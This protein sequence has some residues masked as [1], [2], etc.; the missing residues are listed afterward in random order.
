MSERSHDRRD[1]LAAYLLGALE[2]GEMAELDRHLAG[3]E[4]CREQLTWLRPAVQAIPESIERLDAPPALRERLMAEV[5]DDAEVRAEGVSFSSGWRKRFDDRFRLSSGWRKRSGGG[6]G[7]FGLR[8][9]A[10]LAAVILVMV[11]AVA[12]YTIRDGGSGGATTVVADQPSGIQVAMVRDGDS[13]TLKLANMSQ[14]PTD[15]VMQVWVR[16][17]TRVTP[18]KAPLFRPDAS[19][20]ATVA[21]SDMDG[22]DAV[23]VSAEPRGGSAQPTSAPVVNVPIPN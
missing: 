9:A 2:P 12:G 5:R 17:G 20:A 22:A 4:R 21:I 18:A 16:H 15:K 6:I 1:E 3:C 11:A 14:A 13:G 19:G 7:S 8:P 10:G 23:M